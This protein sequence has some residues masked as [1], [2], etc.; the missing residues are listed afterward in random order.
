MVLLVA[1]LVGWGLLSVL[2]MVGAA[3]VCRA[4]HVEDVAQGF[5]EPELEP[6]SGRRAV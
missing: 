4:G 1:V 5:A 2:G 3:A 6:V